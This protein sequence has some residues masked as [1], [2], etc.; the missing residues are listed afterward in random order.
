ML[1]N[2]HLA[3]KIFVLSAIAKKLAEPY[4]G[5]AAILDYELWE[6]WAEKISLATSVIRHNIYQ[7]TQKS[8]WGD[9][10]GGVPIGPY[11]CPD[12]NSTMPQLPSSNFQALARRT[13][14]PAA[15]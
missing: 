12:Y 3:T 10:R 8:W 15:W 11:K 6:P 1:E 4:Q 13:I 14:R 2:S 9:L 5:L 7:R